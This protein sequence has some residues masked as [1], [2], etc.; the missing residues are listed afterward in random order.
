M[1]L[2][3]DYFMIGCS[4]CIIVY[5]IWSLVK[6]LFEQNVVKNVV[7]VNIFNDC[8]YMYVDIIFIQINIYDYV[9][10]KFIIVDGL[11][12]NVQVMCFDGSEKIYYFV[13]EFLIWEIDFKIRVIFVGKGEFFY[14]DW[15]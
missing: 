12:L 9:V 3:K 13:Q 10:F 11:G 7:Q 4:E 6:C 2:N 14:Q 1:I 15:E 5:G 8:L